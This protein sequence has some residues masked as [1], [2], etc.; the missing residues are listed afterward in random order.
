MIKSKYIKNLHIIVA[1][2]FSCFLIANKGANFKMPSKKELKQILSDLE[3]K[4]TMQKHTE[5]AFKNKYWNHKESGI[6]V[7]IISKEA[8]FSSLDKFDSK[9]GWPSFTKPIE[10]DIIE[11]KNDF[12]LLMKR[13]ELIAKKTQSHLGH[14][15][16]DGPTPTHQRYCVNSAALDFVH[17]RDLEKKGYK[18]YL[19]LFDKQKET[20]FDIA[21][22]SGGCFWC[23]Q[24]AFDKVN[25]VTKTIV[26]YSGGEIKNPTYEMI[27]SGKTKHIESIRIH[28]D[29][30]LISYDELLSIFW[31][32]IDP[33][34]KNRQFC[35]IGSQYRSAIFFHNKEQEKSANKQL[36]QIKNKLTTVYTELIQESPFYAAEEYHQK[37][38]IKNPIRY[39]IYKSSCGRTL[40]LKQLW[41]K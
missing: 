9:T 30:S 3:Y 26:G 20:T 38:Y 28:Y 29:K 8:L 18:K 40:R 16:K 24:E 17:L 33:T 15:F 5:P 10:P 4:V 1:I 35:D 19:H 2:F 7:D 14:V 25:G 41:S 36:N 13:I 32:N 22:F 27:S 31:K 6:Y 23:M 11:Y 12:F 37:Y 21:T 34:V 39:K